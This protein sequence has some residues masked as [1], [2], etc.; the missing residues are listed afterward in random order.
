MLIAVT[1]A[2]KFPFNAKDPTTPKFLLVVSKAECSKIDKS[3]ASCYGK[4]DD[5]VK[6]PIQSWYKWCSKP[7]CQDVRILKGVEW[8][9]KC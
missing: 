3:E 4:S 1:V 5:F 6:N 9:I 7:H 8:S 2:F